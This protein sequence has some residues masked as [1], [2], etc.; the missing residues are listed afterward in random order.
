MESASGIVDASLLLSLLLPA[1]LGLVCVSVLSVLLYDRWQ[2]WQAQRRSRLGPAESARSGDVPQRWQ[3]R[4]RLLPVAHVLGIGAVGAGATGYCAYRGILVLA[5]LSAVGTGIAVWFWRGHLHERWNRELDRQTFLLARHLRTRL[6]QGVTLLVA[7][8][9]THKQAYTLHAPLRDEV[10]LLLRRVAAGE[11]LAGVLTSS[12]DSPRYAGTHIYDRLLFHLGQATTEYMGPAR[13]ADLLETFLEVAT[14][15]RDTQRTLD[16][17]IAQAKY[18]RWIV[19]GLL[20]VV[21]LLIMRLAPEFG[22]HLLYHPAGN[23]ALGLA[24]LLAALAFGIGKRL[25]RLEPL[26]F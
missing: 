16:A 11:T 3:R 18:A 10:D 6:Q 8:E 4:P 1:G 9:Q 22:A 26:K 7:L 25:A 14:L 13:T 5:L 23:V 2:T 20:P 21:T 24:A 17:R 15:V 12:A 19:A